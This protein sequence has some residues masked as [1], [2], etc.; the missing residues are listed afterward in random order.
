MSARDGAPAAGAVGQD[1]NEAGERLLYWA[2][3]HTLYGRETAATVGAALM[4]AR[5]HTSD[6]V[7]TAQIVYGL[8]TGRGPYT[9]PDSPPP[10]STSRLAGRIVAGAVA[11]QLA[12]HRDTLPSLRGRDMSMLA[13]RIIGHYWEGSAGLWVRRAQELPTGP[14]ECLHLRRESRLHAQELRR[15]GL[16]KVVTTLTAFTNSCSAE[17]VYGRLCRDYWSTYSQARAEPLG[18]AL[19]HIVSRHHHPAE[20]DVLA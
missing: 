10:V 16:E 19:D 13:N 15:L 11:L 7:P 20:A 14:D 8:V 1:Q 6:G 3:Q 18:A 4:Y 5:P 9:D 2:G 12:R 17:A